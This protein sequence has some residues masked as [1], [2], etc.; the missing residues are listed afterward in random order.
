MDIIVYIILFKF[1]IFIDILSI[2]LLSSDVFITFSNRVV[3]NRA[4]GTDKGNQT[5]IDKFLCKP[6]ISVEII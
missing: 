6:S 3:I 4:K 5:D 1:L 2:N